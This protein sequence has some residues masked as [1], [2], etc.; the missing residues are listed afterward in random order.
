MQVARECTFKG[1]SIC[2]PGAKI[3]EIGEI[4][5]YFLIY[6]YFKGT[7]EYEWVCC[8]R[9]IWRA[10]NWERNAYASIYTSYK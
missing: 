10:W 2:K 7:C 9:F 5:E 1:I 3:N 8:M 6:I 4:I